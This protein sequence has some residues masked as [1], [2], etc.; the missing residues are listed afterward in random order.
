[1]TRGTASQRANHDTRRSW[2]ITKPLNRIAFSTFSGMSGLYLFHSK[3]CHLS[4]S[5]NFVLF[6]MR[7]DP[8]FKVG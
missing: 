2:K 6:A 5:P 3:V 4:L 8:Q 7:N 1:M